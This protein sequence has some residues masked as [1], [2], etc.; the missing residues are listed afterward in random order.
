M[1]DTELLPKP[2]HHAGFRLAADEHIQIDAIPG[3]DDKG[4]PAGRHLRLIAGGW[5]QQIGIVEPIYTDMPPV[6]EVDAVRGKELRT[7]NGVDLGLQPLFL[8]LR[9]DLADAIR[10]RHGAVAAQQVIKR[11]DCEFIIV[12][13]DQHL[14]TALL[15]VVYRGAGRRLQGGDGLIFLAAAFPACP[16]LIFKYHEEA[17]CGSFPCTDPVN[18]RQIVLLQQAA[19]F[20]GLLCHLLLHDLP[21][22]VQ[23]GS[24]GNDLDLHFDRA[25]LQERDERI[26]DVPLLSGAAQQEVDRHDLNDL[27]V[28]VIPCVDD[29]VFDSFHRQIFRHGI[30][31]LGCGV[32]ALGFMLLPFLPLALF[33]LIA[34]N[35]AA[36]MEIFQDKEDERGQAFAVDAHQGDNAQRQR[37]QAQNDD[38]GCQ[39]QCGDREHRYADSQHDNQRLGCVAELQQSAEKSPALNK[40]GRDDIGVIIIWFTHIY[41][42][43]LS[44]DP[45]RPTGAGAAAGFI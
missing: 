1:V 13:R 5:H 25:D 27:Q 10:Q 32:T 22:P 4:Q 18:E 24:L 31:V 43:F 45:E 34:C 9:D 17:A 36:V 19:V 30:D 21:M 38:L 39:C 14:I 23:V 33:L 6:G 37:G 2:L 3:V 11:I 15:Q 28:A 40:V 16:C 8:V 41:V 12:F 20:I 35:N 7:G 29:A 44:D 42:S 26:D